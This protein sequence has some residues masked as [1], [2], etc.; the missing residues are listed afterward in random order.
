MTKNIVYLLL[1]LIIIVN[2]NTCLS[3]ALPDEGDMAKLTGANVDSVFIATELLGRPTDTSVTLNLLANKDLTL[4][5]EYGKDAFN[6]RNQTN[7]SMYREGVPIEIVIENLL[8][9]TRYYY[10]ILHRDP[11]SSEFKV[12]DLNS[13]HTQRDPGSAFTFAVE[14]DPHLDEQSNPDIYKKTLQNILVYQPDFLFDLGDTFMSDK[15]IKK[16]YDEVV[17]R[18]LMMRSYFDLTCH[19]VPLFLVIGNHEGELGWNLDGTPENLAVWATNARKLYYPNPFPDHYYSGNSTI[20]DFVGLREDYYAFEWGDA[21][22]IVLDPYWNTKIKPG[23]SKNNWDWT[24]GHRQYL[25]M[26]ETLEN[27]HAR[28]KFVFC[29]QLVGGKDTEGRGGSEY[30]GYFE[31][32]GLNENG[33][34]GFDDNRPGWD[35]PIHQLM[36]EY[37]IAIF[38]HGH[39]HFFAKQELD[40]VIYQLVPQ[41]SHPNY[42]RAGQAESYGYITGE[43]LPNSGHLRVSV[44][45]SEVTVEYV[46]TYLAEDEDV[47]AGRVNGKTD[48]SFTVQAATTSVHS[49][50]MP[51]TY[52]LNQNYPN[53]F[54]PVTTISFVLAEAQRVRL[55]VYDVSGKLVKTLV[56]ARLSAGTHSV[57]WRADN[58]P[59][60]IYLYT[61]IYGSSTETKRMILLR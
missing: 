59:S 13:F 37:G 5:V 31:W 42:R 24:L 54:N 21:L 2:A 36:V 29:H 61:M 45:D 22:F 44:S 43:I 40:G 27:S 9:N 56:N 52:S 16:N 8:P 48:Y 26:K 51:N 4:Y 25:W 33:T 58:L 20:E 14:A 15:L 38:F 39:D 50:N 12:R 23:N 53:P 41:P 46:R 7:V 34:W 3:C 49:V 55:K 35:R 1:A 30:A 18:H 28:F 17:N 57:R 60:G 19:S 6:L 32:G 47:V 10:R 11:D